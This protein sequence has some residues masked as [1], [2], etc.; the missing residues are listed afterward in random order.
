MWNCRHCPG[1]V[2][3]GGRRSGGGGEG[4]GERKGQEDGEDDED[5]VGWTDRDGIARE[6]EGEPR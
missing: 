5:L 6:I 3:E 2:D 1:F 4:L